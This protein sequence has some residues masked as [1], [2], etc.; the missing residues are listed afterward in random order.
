MPKAKRTRTTRGKSSRGSQSSA[1]YGFSRFNHIIDHAHQFGLAEFKV[2]LLLIRYMNA[3]TL[4][5][6]SPEGVSHRQ[7]QKVT[8]LSPKSVNAAVRSLTTPDPNRVCW[9]EKLPRESIHAGHRYRL[10]A[11]ELVPDHAGPGGALAALHSLREVGINAEMRI[12]TMKKD[13]TKKYK[14]F[15]FDESGKERKRYFELPYDTGGDLP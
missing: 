7:I 8:G 14:V 13:G 9:L 1:P 11:P 4:E 15:Y 3:K 2:L 12:V 10:I 6:R 5:T